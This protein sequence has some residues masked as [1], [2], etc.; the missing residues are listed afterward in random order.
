M[1]KIL[2]FMLV[3]MLVLSLGKVSFAKNVTN[4]LKDGKLKIVNIEEPL[5]T[6]DAKYIFIDDNM[7]NSTSMGFSIMGVIQEMYNHSYY[8]V[9]SKTLKGYNVGPTNDRKFLISAARGQTV[10]LE[11]EKSVSSTVT[12]SGTVEAKIK[13]VINVN[14][15]SITSGTYE[16]I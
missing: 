12:Y 10:Y 11:E 15:I 14:S 3:F 8:V 6:P 7:K 1:K 5:G 9:G 16:R 13:K 2:S 4:G